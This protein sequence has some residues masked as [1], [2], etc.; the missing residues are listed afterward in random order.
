[1]TAAAV[2]LVAAPQAS[3]LN[4]LL[5]NDDGFG[6][7][8]ITAVQTALEGAGHTVYV[9]APADNQSGKSGAI[10]TDHGGAVAFTEHV[11]GK[12]WSVEGTPVDSVSAGLFALVPAGVEIDLV[13]S[14]ANDGENV[15]LFTNASGTVGAAMFAVRRGTP[16]IAVSVGQ[17][18]AS[19]A[20]IS[21][22]PPP[23]AGY[24]CILPLLAIA[25]ANAETGA[26]TAAALV[27]ALI[28]AVEDGEGFGEGLALNVNVPSGAYT[29]KGIRVVRSDNDL[30]FDLVILPDGN[31]GLE[32]GTTRDNLLVGALI[33][34]VQ[35]QYLPPG[36]IDYDS[37]GQAF[38]CG[39][40]TVSIVDGNIDASQDTTDQAKD[41][42]C[43]LKDLATIEIFN[44]DGG[45]GKGKKDD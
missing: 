26:D 18:I 42:A 6:T 3:A 24:S 40:T 21:A 38:A 28:A 25:E 23:P 32:V 37:E 20:A 30:A 35:C 19:L 7:Y 39:Y 31:G 4:I 12:S 14:G 16:S 36:Y 17:D 13:V 5:T 22:C 2:L 44:C 15:S 34:Q 41:L 11:V 10:N 33:G 1:M 27:P 43:S 29:P 8:G 9:S 45:D